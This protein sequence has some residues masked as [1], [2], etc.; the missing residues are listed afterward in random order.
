[1]DVTARLPPR[2]PSRLAPPQ[3]EVTESEEEGAIGP[4][5]TGQWRYECICIISLFFLT[6]FMDG[7]SSSGTDSMPACSK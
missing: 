7:G 4:G 3:H 1:M 5:K 2:H 6:L